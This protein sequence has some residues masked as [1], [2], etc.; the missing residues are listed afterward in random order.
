MFTPNPELSREMNAGDANDGELAAVGAWCKPSDTF[1]DSPEERRV[2]VS[3]LP[4]D[5]VDGDG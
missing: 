3:D 5:L 1:E 4:A 2:V